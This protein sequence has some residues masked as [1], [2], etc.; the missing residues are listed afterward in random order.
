MLL[1]KALLCS[2]MATNFELEKRTASIVNTLPAKP[3]FV[4]QYSS[5][6]RTCTAIWL[7]SNKSVEVH[8]MITMTFGWKWGDIIGTDIT[9]LPCY[10]EYCSPDGIWYHAHPNYNNEGSWYN[11]GLI[12]FEQLNRAESTDLFLCQILFFYVTQEE[13]L[14]TRPRNIHVVVE[15]STYRNKLGNDKRRKDLLYDTGICSHWQLSKSK[16]SWLPGRGPKPYAPHI[17]SVPV[18]F[19]KENVLVVEEDPGLKE[20][21]TGSRCIWVL[22]DRRVSWA[23]LFGV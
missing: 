1:D 12:R 17:Y 21:Y 11:W 16:A 8:P 13:G 4:L 5:M 15:A 3:S 2:S 7:G 9:A 14:S 10:T 23:S 22:T 18:K 19:L 6:T 20:T